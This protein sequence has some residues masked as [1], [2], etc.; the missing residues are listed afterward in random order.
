[1]YTLDECARW[2]DEAGRHGGADE[3]VRLLQRW[4]PFYALA[5]HGTD[6]DAGPFARE[7][8]FVDRLAAEGFVRPGDTVLD[9]G[10]GVGD[11]ALAFARRGARVTALD[12]SSDCLEACVGRARAEG[13]DGVDALL[14]TWEG[15]AADESFDLAFSAMCPAI[16]NVDELR[17]M[18][19]S[20]RR[21]CC[22]VT[23]GRG[24]SDRHRKAMMAELRIKPQG[25]FATEALHYFNVLYL[26]GRQPNVFCLETRRSSRVTLEEALGRFPVYFEAFG[27]PDAVSRPY[28]EEYFARNA[29][30][31]ALEDET[32]MKY[33]MVY[34]RLPDA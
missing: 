30:D 18:E 28:V 1:M 19:A 12:A 3:R 14:G 8:P 25:G 15:F 29:V 33:A 4:L 23:V 34:W 21:A 6:A 22:I 7:D 11:H 32:V 26:M 13:L 27:I 24:S 2:W 31:G 17:R 20:A 9:I 10:S 5:A 16:C